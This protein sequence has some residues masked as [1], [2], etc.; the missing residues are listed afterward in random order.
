MQN[1]RSLVIS[2]TANTYPPALFR[3]C[4]AVIGSVCAASA[5]HAMP[6]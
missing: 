3:T 5:A 4:V 2:S 6:F 1:L